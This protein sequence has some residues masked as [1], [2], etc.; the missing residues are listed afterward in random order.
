M[1]VF[2]VDGKDEALGLLNSL[3]TLV[4]KKAFSLFQSIKYLCVDLFS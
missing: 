2:P 3:L 4:L 1:N